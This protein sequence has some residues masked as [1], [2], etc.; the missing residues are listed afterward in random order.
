MNDYFT[1]GRF[2]HYLICLVSVCL[3]LPAVSHAQTY[4]N[5]QTTG[6]TGLCLLC[7]VINPGNAVDN[8]NLN[9]YSE[10][11][12]TVG[13]L[14]VTVY[15]TLIFP[16]TG[17]TAC[18]SLVI[19]IGSSNALL[20]ANLLGGVSVQTFNGTIPNNDSVT[21]SAPVLRLL[22][23]NTRGEIVL[24]PNRP[25]DRVRLTLNSSLLGLLNNFRIYYAYRRAGK[26]AAPVFTVPQGIACGK[27][28]L[29]ITNHTKGI[30]YNV[31]I[32][33]TSFTLPQPIDTAFVVKNNDTIVTPDPISYIY[34]QADVYVQAVNPFTGCKSD[35]ARKSYVQGGYAELP[36]AD[37]DSVTICKK[38]TARL[39]AYTPSSTIPVIR[40]YNAPAGGIL[41]HTGSYYAVSPDTNT[42]YYVTAA[43]D[44]EHQQRRPVKVIVRKLPDPVYT[45][46]G[47]FVCGSSRLP[48]LNHQPGYN[49]R[50]RII[51]T[52]FSN[53]LADTAYVVY[54]RDTIFV[55]A[56]NPVNGA[57]AAVYVQAVDPLSGC[58]SDSV[59]MVF[60]LGGTPGLPLVDKDSIAVCRGSNATLHGY[61]TSSSLLQVR[62]YDAPVGG[63]LLY[64]GN[65]FTVNPVASTVYYVS[66]MGTCESQARKPVKVTVL[67]CSVAANSSGYNKGKEDGTSLTASPNPTSGEVKFA[68]AAD[69]TG[70]VIVVYDQRGKEVFYGVL[71][72]AVFRFPSSIIPGIYMIR[73][74]TPSRKQYTT[75]ILLIR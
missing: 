74:T 25:Y 34:L 11:N 19:G 48:V 67:S 59:R 71:Q 4:A 9:D 1:H 26:P 63:Q 40:W 57:N 46:P 13:L 17:T 35:T 41:L 27:Q 38:D 30:D 15:Q 16:A 20:S 10:F 42:T 73:I 44:C 18:D 75:R 49:Y 70:G 22:Q 64:T 72:Q 8:T 21:V 45:V 58:R 36:V 3:L 47:G 24:K 29:V 32:R 54:N 62:W 65:Y 66:G 31:R 12:I 68:A 14:G 60:T 33:Y 53:P 2:I 23:S 39:H 61:Y 43:L 69:L 50:V 55:P 56:L 7:G 37:A 6:V 52:L 5:N 28:K 51:Y